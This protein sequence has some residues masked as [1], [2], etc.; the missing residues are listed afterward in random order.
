MNG[1]DM[2]QRISEDRARSMRERRTQ[3]ALPGVTLPTA[4]MMVQQ[5]HGSALPNSPMSKKQPQHTK[6]AAQKLVGLG[7]LLALL[8]LAMYP[9]LAAMDTL[10]D[11]ATQEE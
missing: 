7:L 2:Q 3:P 5:Q 11:R 4:S 9:L 6:R 10:P 1:E 8:Y